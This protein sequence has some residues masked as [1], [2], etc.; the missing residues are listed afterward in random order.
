MNSDSEAIAPSGDVEPSDVETAPTPSGLPRPSAV[1]ML[2]L[3]LAATVLG[4]VLPA[5]L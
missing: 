4:S 5:Y 1:F 3:V 2:F